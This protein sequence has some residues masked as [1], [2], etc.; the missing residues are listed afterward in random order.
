MCDVS[1]RMKDIFCSCHD[2]NWRTTFFSG[3][4]LMPNRTHINILNSFQQLPRDRA[5]RCG[6]TCIIICVGVYRFVTQNYHNSNINFKFDWNFWWWSYFIKWI[7]RFDP[8]FVCTASVAWLTKLRIKRVYY[9]CVCLFWCIH[10]VK[11]SM[12]RW[13][14]CIGYAIHYSWRAIMAFCSDKSAIC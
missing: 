10:S 3:R 9:V 7:I 4:I 5:S 13:C 2:P 14:L 12:I 11:V 1:L 6:L 8:I